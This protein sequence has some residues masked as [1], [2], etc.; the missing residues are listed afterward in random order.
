VVL[1]AADDAAAVLLTWFGGQEFGTALGDILS[2]AEEPGGRLPTTWPRTFEDVPVSNVTPEDGRLNYDEGIHIGY[3]AWLHA[4]REP[5]YWFGQ[6]EG[7][8]TFGTGLRHVVPAADG[9]EVVV[10]VRNT[11]TRAGKHIVQVYA[12][13]PESAIDRPSRWLAGF[14]T[15]HLAPGE[16]TE[17]RVAVPRRA[18]AHW[19]GGWSYEPG[20][21]ELAVARSAG[22]PG[23][24]VRLTIQDD[25]RR[26]ASSA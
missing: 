4:D 6:G 12:S 20:E 22:D 3:R 15:V 7:Y 24:V 18:F 13:R 2:G 5:L 1:P 11:G 8:S 26:S 25:G 9:F 16:H 10:E 21:F 17:V 23:E 14:Q 19:D